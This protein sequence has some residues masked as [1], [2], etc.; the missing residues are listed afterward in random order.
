MTCKLQGFAAPAENRPMPH[1]SRHLSVLVKPLWV[2]V[3]YLGLAV[4]LGNVPWASTHALELALTF[5]AA[6]WVADF[7]TGLT[8]LT[9]DYCALNFNKGFGRLY[10]YPGPRGGEE[11]IRI[12][13]QVMQ[14]ASWLDAKVYTF[15]IHHRQARS[16]CKSSYSDAVL[17][18]LPAALWMVVAGL[19]LTWAL[20]SHPAAPYVLFFH[21]VVSFFLGHAQFVHYC[22]HVSDTMLRG[23][24]LVRTLSQR[25][26]IYSNRTHAEHHKEGLVGFC[27]ITGHANFAVDWLCKVLLARGWIHRDDWFGRPRHP[28]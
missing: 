4:C 8:H 7:L 11:F 1:F 12:K 16:N 6:L 10:D 3:Y 26:L 13:Q 27:L 22:M 17:E 25:H 9:I 18:F 23:N 19:G 14:G 15:K 20:G 24:R 2:G 21:V 5:L 28:I